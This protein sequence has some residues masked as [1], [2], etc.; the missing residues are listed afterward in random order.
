MRA[1]LG[2]VGLRSGRQI[3]PVDA[4]VGEVWAVLVRAGLAPSTEETAEARP[5]VIGGRD[6]LISS[7]STIVEA[8]PMPWSFAVP[9]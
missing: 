9:E 2:P 5:D 1:R 4:V 6:G 3:R 7:A 8:E